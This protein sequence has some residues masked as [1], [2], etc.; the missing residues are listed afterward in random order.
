MFEIFKLI[1][2]KTTIIGL[3]VSFFAL[4]LPGFA[5]LSGKKK[6][7]DNIN[8]K[9]LE[10][11]LENVRRNKKIDNYIDNMDRNTRLD[12]MREFERKE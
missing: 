5:F 10:D 1:P 4:I 6:G 12:W 7:V 9:N 3:I 8:N 2:F 11:D